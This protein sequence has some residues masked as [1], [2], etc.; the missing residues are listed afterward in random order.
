MHSYSLSMGM[1]VCAGNVV[2]VKDRVE[3]E[4]L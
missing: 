1:A 2:G 3:F 4:P